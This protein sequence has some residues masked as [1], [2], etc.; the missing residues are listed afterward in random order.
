MWW[1]LLLAACVA[2]ASCSPR[3][4]ESGNAAAVADPEV[5]LDAAD[6]S[7]PASSNAV[8]AESSDPLLRLASSPAFGFD[9]ELDK[10][11]CTEQDHGG[12]VFYSCDPTPL[13]PCPFSRGNECQ[14]E[15]EFAG[16][17]LDT[18]SFKYD[19]EDF[20]REGFIRAASS[21]FG[22]SKH[23]KDDARR[24]GIDQTMSTWEW[25]SGKLRIQIFD[26]SG[27]N[28]EGDPYHDVSVDF[29][30]SAIPDA[31]TAIQSG[32]AH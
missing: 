5:N 32:A 25:R 24:S 30:N 1:K 28:F 3:S 13:Q 10:S 15:A 29:R 16:D 27:A 12:I 21:E 6:R 2:L 26:T 20:D 22:A 31:M 23:K 8:S 19:P 7:D 4:T 14:V 9:A 18:L 17:R 11:M